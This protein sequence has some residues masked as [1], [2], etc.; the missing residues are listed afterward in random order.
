MAK[1]AGGRNDCWKK[2]GK[3]N[4]RILMLSL[5][6]FF[7]KPFLYML[8]NLGL[9]DKSDHL[10]LLSVDR[11]LQ[12]Y[13]IPPLKNGGCKSVVISGATTSCIP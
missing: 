5:L 11:C 12:L 9:L 6:D 7:L 4:Y 8:N 3:I 10:S 1:A 13:L 2:N